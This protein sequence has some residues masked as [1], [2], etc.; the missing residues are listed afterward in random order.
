[1]IRRGGPTFYVRRQTE[2]GRGSGR[3]DAVI[4]RKNRSRRQRE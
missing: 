4:K 3:K 1:M 2:G